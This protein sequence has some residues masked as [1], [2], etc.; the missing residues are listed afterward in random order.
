[1]TPATRWA[2]SPDTRAT[3][4]GT[5]QTLVVRF[6][7][8]APFKSNPMMSAESGLSP[9]RPFFAGG[10]CDKCTPVSRQ[11]QVGALA[12]TRGLQV[13]SASPPPSSGPWSW[14]PF[15]RWGEGRRRKAEGLAAREREA[16]ARREAALEDVWQSELVQSHVE[17]LCGEEGGGMSER[18]CREELAAL[19]DLLGLEPPDEEA[20]AGAAAG[21][22]GGRCRLVY[23]PGQLDAVRACHEGP[24]FPIVFVTFDR[25][26]SG[27]RDSP[28]LA[29]AL[30]RRELG[31]AVRPVDFRADALAGGV[32]VA[33][34]SSGQEDADLGE[35]AN[36]AENAALLHLL[37][38]G[39]NFVLDLR[40]EGGMSSKKRE[41]VNDLSVFVQTGKLEDVYLVPFAV[42][43][44]HNEAGGDLELMKRI[45]FE[46]PFSL[47]VVSQRTILEIL[48]G[49]LKDSFAGVH[50]LLGAGPPGLQ[51]QRR[52]G[53]L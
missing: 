52:G 32:S 41:L 24:G 9:E 42:S 29:W 26:V 5:Q 14:W 4:S 8:L 21:L 36:A 23:H 13:A 51:F 40:Y 44:D 31:V 22:L 53:G 50:R 16:S 7:A 47:K 10:A 3:S 1:M 6:Q 20:A 28:H 49:G 30:L 35:L 25:R 45:D 34:L 43:R 38:S 12:K 17:Y 15:S 33:L 39:S 18:D 2:P 48:S 19:V 11:A 37:R 27:P 46:Q